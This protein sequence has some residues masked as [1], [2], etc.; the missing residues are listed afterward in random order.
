MANNY[1]DESFLQK[2]SR[3]AKSLNSSLKQFGTIKKEFGRDVALAKLKRELRLISPENYIDFMYSKFENEFKS[4]IDDYKN[5]IDKKLAD[6]NSNRK[7][8]S[9]TPI[10]VC[11]FQGKDSVPDLCQA[12]LNRIEELKPDNAEIIF[13]TKDNYL[14]YVDFPSEIIEKFNNGIIGMANYS[15][16]IR[17]Y[18]LST[19]GGMWIDAAIFLSNDVI[20]KAVN[21]DFYSIRFS[22]GKA[23]NGDI[24]RGLWCNGFLSETKPSIISDFSYNCYIEFWKKYNI[25]MDYLLCD[26]ILLLGY[27][28]ID[29][30]RSTVDMTPLSSNEFRKLNYNLSKPYSVE[31]W[32]S[33]M[34]E[35]DIHLLNRHFDYPITTP[36]GVKTIYGHMLEITGVICN[37]KE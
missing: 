35:S 2:F 37:E 6:M 7:E 16:I 14:D 1:I 27:E 32:N 33:I 20:N 5:N 34:S 9:K 23:F 19:Y 24:S 31:L 17:H 25:A 36:E 30:I 29:V 26:F 13:L 22:D 4:I 15:D 8:T 12:C 18:L 10:W 3:N 11:W 21:F 28:N